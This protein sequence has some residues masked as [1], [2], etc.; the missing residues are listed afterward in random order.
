MGI[1]K[2]RYIFVK[3]GYW[4]HFVPFFHTV[5]L[6]DFSLAL[7]LISGSFQLAVMFLVCSFV[8]R[9]NQ[10]VPVPVYLMPSLQI[11]Q[12]LSSG[13]GRSSSN[14]NIGICQLSLSS[15]S[16]ALKL[17]LDMLLFADAAVAFRVLYKFTLLGWTLT[18][19]QRLW[20]GERVGLRETRNKT[21][22]EGSNKLKIL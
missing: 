18:V 12:L 8:P 5:A 3:V 14:S 2:N 4:F 10:F 1:S 6:P 16:G 22:T 15:S 13:H 20:P 17:T 21:Q 19:V 9:T 7:W 11:G